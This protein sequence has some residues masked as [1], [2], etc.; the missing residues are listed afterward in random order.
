MRSH[1]CIAFYIIAVT[2]TFDNYVTV[3][4]TFDYY[5]TVT[6]QSGL[7]KRFLI[8]AADA[9][10]SALPAGEQPPK[11]EPK[12]AREP[13]QETFVIDREKVRGLIFPF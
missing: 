4:L 8:M 5:V 12:E 11:V 10:V 9:V 2:L 1:V 7:G 3:T 13:V 6:R